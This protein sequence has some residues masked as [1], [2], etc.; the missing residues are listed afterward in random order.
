MDAWGAAVKEKS[1]PRAHI[2]DFNFALGIGPSVDCALPSFAIAAA[3][4]TGKSASQHASRS[5]PCLH[6]RVWAV[7]AIWVS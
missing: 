1:M 5:M 6:S 3:S 7:A 2:A 4:D